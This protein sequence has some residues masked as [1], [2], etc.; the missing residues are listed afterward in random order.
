MIPWPLVVPAEK[1]PPSLL[2]ASLVL[3]YSLLLIIADWQDWKE[4]KGR[5]NLQLAGLCYALMKLTQSMDQKRDESD[6]F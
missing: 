3:A 4:S 1:K 6:T 2:V 5:S